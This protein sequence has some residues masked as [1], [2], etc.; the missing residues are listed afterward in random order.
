[1]EYY[2]GLFSFASVCRSDSREMRAVLPASCSDQPQGE[3]RQKARLPPISIYTFL[4][5]HTQMRSVFMVVV[6]FGL[7]PHS[8]GVTDSSWQHLAPG[9][10]LKVLTG[11][12][13]NSVGDS[14]ITVLRIDPKLW[15]LEFFGIS[16]TGESQGHTARAWCEKHKL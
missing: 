13:P 1:M 6:L 5:E 7:Q 2:P 12:T 14:R 8:T 4:A 9:M 16:Q 11:S 15:E 10:D 3:M